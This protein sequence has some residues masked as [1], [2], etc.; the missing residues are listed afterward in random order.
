MRAAS[1]SLALLVLFADFSPAAPA[2]L[3]LGVRLEWRFVANRPFYQKV[4]T[5]TAQKMKVSGTEVATTQQQTFLIRWSPVKQLP[6]RSWVVKY[7]IEALQFE[8]DVAGNKITYDS[9]NSNA[10]NPLASTL[11]LFVGAELTLT[12]N[13][14]KQVTKVEGREALLARLARADPTFKAT[15][16]A[17]FTDDA[18]KGVADPLF[19]TLP[20]GKLA[21]GT[22]WAEQGKMDMGPIGSLTTTTRYVFEGPDARE[23]RLLR[24]GLKRELK[25][26]PPAGGAGAGGLPYKVK[27]ASFKDAH[28]TGTIHVDPKKGRVERAETKMRLTGTLSVDVGGN[29]TDLELDQTQTTTV[30]TSDSLPAKAKE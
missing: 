16:E 15:I 5:R 11:D 13:P 20:G 18:L 4:V 7:R 2:P 8:F 14:R 10:K 30:T 9:A 23:R 28:A 26:A 1:F 19:A 22:T 24:V 27:G 25:Y 6:D 12:L 21:K 29:S 3:D 17:F